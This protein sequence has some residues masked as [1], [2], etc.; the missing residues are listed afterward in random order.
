MAAQP[1]AAD[2]GATAAPMPVLMI[3]TGEYTTG[4]GKESSKTDKGA[5]GAGLRCHHARAVST[6]ILL[7]SGCHHDV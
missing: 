3:G 5:G 1:A 4:F 7:R 6:A 2:A